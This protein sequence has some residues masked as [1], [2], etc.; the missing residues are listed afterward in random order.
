MTPQDK[1]ALEF[2][3]W[4]KN[5]QYKGFKSDEELLRIFKKEKGL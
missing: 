5:Y 2:A 3:R 4:Y 1:F